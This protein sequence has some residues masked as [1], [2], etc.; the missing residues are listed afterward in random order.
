M[1]AHINPS[2]IY[3]QLYL[4]FISSKWEIPKYEI[5]EGQMFQA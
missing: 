5:I 3:L 1:I 4:C 2:D